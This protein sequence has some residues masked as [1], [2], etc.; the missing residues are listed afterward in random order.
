[1]YDCHVHSHFSLD[2]ELDP[3]T[4]CEVAIKAG[5][6]GIA[7]T[8]H[9][10]YDFPNIDP[11][12]N[13]D[14]DTY[15]RYM[16]NLKAKYKARL[17]VLKGVEVGIQPHVIEDSLQLVKKYDFDYVLASV[18]ILDGIDPYYKDSCY[19]KDKTK[20]QAYSRY[21]EEILFMVTHFDDFDV[22]GHFDY[23]I[24]YAPY[25]DR[26]FRYDDHRDLLD[27]IFKELIYKGRGF[28]INTG[29]YR[30]RSSGIAGP[31]KKAPEYDIALLKRF[32]ELG[33][34]IVC[35]GSDSHSPEY[36]G[37]KFSY[38]SG[39][40]LEAGFKYVTHFEGRKPV[41]TKITV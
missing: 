11:N 4:A 9:M 41:F 29:S 24:R 33:G 16:D 22:A 8:D 35:L 26:S 13:I 3:I 12:L 10:D 14:F 21:F 38:F 20:L 40:L 19:Y 34:E 30:E 18:H 2:S 25:D 23:I 5:L 1:M 28:E 15:S 31:D 37:Y 27:S 6:E 7:F 32:R 17:K 36:I 39:L